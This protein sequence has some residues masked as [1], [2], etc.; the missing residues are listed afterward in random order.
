MML[1]EIT[2]LAG[3]RRRR[4]RVGRGESSGHGKTC[5]R[6]DKGMQSRAGNGPHPLFE[7]GATPLY[8]KSP[9]RGFNNANFRRE[10]AIVNLDDIAERFSA[11]DTVNAEALRKCNLIPS[12][13]APVKVLGRG[14]LSVKLTI[15]AH[16]ASA[17]AKAAVEKAGGTFRLIE[18]RDPAAAAKN[19]RKSAK[20][21]KRE[22]RPSRIEKKKA[23]RA[24]GQ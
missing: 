11:G 21:R 5:G 22:A 14:E 18:S 17:A 16:G 19:K 7:G 24:A 20:G 3:A 2:G 15:E 8:R 12:A 6:G 23:A 4:K 9:K 1:N 13:D 10:Y